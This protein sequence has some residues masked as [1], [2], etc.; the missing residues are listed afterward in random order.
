MNNDV[1][2]NL[3]YHNVSNLLINT[4]FKSDQDNVDASLVKRFYGNFFC[5]VIL[6]RS[7]K[8]QNT[9]FSKTTAKFWYLR[10]Q[11]G[12]NAALCIASR[13]LSC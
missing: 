8:N 10:K 4:R 13:S 11:A 7:Y 5:L 12:V 2:K 6:K 1:L 3:V 9:K